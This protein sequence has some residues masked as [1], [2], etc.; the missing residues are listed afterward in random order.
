MPGIYITRGMTVSIPQFSIRFREDGEIESSPLTLHVRFDVCPTWVQI[1][2]RHLAAALA[3]R[4]SRETAWQGTDEDAKAQA[5]EVEFEASMQAIMAAAVAWDAAYAVLREHVTIP[6]AMTDTWRNGR[7]ARYTQ[8]AEVVRRAFSLK[9]K[10]A[11]L[12]RS[13]LKEIYRYRDLAVHPSG[14]IEAPL[15]HPELNLGMEWRFV[16]FRALNAEVAV[17]A[18]AAML[19]DLANNGKSK[20]PKVTEYQKTLATRLAEIFPEGAPVIPSRPAAK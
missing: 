16:Y 2:K 1:A 13:N 7:T 11:A 4:I 9:P 3:A 15:L 8:V 20:D 10:G 17:Q 12:L 5:L 18:A 14:K 6:Q 19:W